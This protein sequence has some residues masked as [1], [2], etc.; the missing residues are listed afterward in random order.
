MDDVGPLIR[1]RQR[2]KR[3]PLLFKYPHPFQ[4]KY[5]LSLFDRLELSLVIAHRG[6]PLLD[7]TCIGHSNKEEGGCQ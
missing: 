5:P 2:K 7:Y 6:L 4:C 1:P 3:H